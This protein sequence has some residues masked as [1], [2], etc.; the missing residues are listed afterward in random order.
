MGTVPVLHR[1]FFEF[2]HRLLDTVE[3]GVDSQGLLIGSDRV[4]GLSQMGMA[5]AQ[6]GPGS[7]VGGHE[8][9]GV[10]AIHHRL[11]ILP[12]EIMCDG[13]LVVRLG[14]FRRKLDS[15]AKMLE[16][17]FELLVRKALRAAC[18]FFVGGWRTTA[19]PDRPQGMFG[20]LI[21]HRI[22]VFESLGHGWY[23]ARSAHKRE[24]Q[25]R[26]FSGITIRA[27]EQ[28]SDL[29]R[30]VMLLEMAQQS[31]QV[32]GLEEGLD[33]IDKLAGIYRC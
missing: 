5:V 9:N 19:K 31:L 23:A 30:R 29:V 18:Q 20:H 25:G 12:L 32:T 15:S 13:P 27:G 24:G 16:G 28:R 21:G 26:D 14:E 2:A 3:V 11:L 22:R 7:K 8:P 1:L 6:A 17:A 10:K 4:L 33:R